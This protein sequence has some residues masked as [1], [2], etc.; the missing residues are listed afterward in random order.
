MKTNKNRMKQFHSYWVLFL[1]LFFITGTLLG[2]AQ[3]STANTA[4]SIIAEINRITANT[5]WSNEAAAK[6][7]VSK[8]ET[9]TKQLNSNT[10][11]DS[12]EPEEPDSPNDEQ[13][14][15]PT[16]NKNVMYAKAL[17]AAFKAGTDALDADFDMAGP[18]REKIKSEYEEEEKDQFSLETKDEPKTLIID[19]TLPEGPKLYKS[20]ANYKM[21]EHLIF[22]NGSYSNSFNVD[23]AVKMSAHLPLKS[24]GFLAFGSKVRTIPDDIGLFKELREI[25]WI[26]NEVVSIPPLASK[27]EL[28]ENLYLDGNPIVQI[29]TSV[30]GLKHLKKIGLGK[31]K[32]TEDELN[33]LKNMF[34][35]CQIL[36]N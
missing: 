18:L 35:A 27:C 36:T 32:I 22:L 24:I 10:I 1:I 21:I 20:L 14:L 17:D 19:F 25:I 28:L 26:G 3:N 23:Q 29:A 15:K 12:T 11:Q 2:H 9:L 33:R 34:P 13:S 7:A 5:N 8:I 31:T 6:A 30:A 4:E 16:L